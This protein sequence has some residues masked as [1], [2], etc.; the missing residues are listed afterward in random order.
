MSIPVG[1]VAIL[2]G[3]LVGGAAHLDARADADEE[4]ALALKEGPGRDLT[5]GMCMV[6]HSLDY[7]P[8]NAPAMDRGTWKKTVQ[9]MRERYGAPITDTQAQTIVDY[10]SA[11]Y[12]GKN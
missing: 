11:S 2:V 8:S 4:S 6:C 12:A 3:L 5:T 10:L 1:R 9:K 7:I